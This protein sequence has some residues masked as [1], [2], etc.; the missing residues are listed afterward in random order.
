MFNKTFCCHYCSGFSCFF[1]LSWRE[2]VKAGFG[3]ALIWKHTVRALSTITFCVDFEFNVID[4]WY[5]VHDVQDSQS[6]ELTIIGDYQCILT[7]IHVGCP[8]GWGTK[9]SYLNFAK[10]GNCKK[11]SWLW[12]IS[13]RC[14]I[15]YKMRL[16]LPL[17][18]IKIG[19]CEVLMRI[20]SVIAPMLMLIS[21]SCAWPL[22]SRNEKLQT[23]AFI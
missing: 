2:D 15:V 16:C 7:L 12:N 14:L 3:Y 8:E 22:A 6:M 21:V 18:I 13:W 9:L 10:I 5:M 11:N 19:G 1:S 23:K 20:I 17:P 4:Q